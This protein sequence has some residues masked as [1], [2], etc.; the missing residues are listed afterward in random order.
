MREVFLSKKPATHEGTS[1]QTGGFTVLSK[2]QPSNFLLFL[3]P[4]N[5][6]LN[7]TPENVDYLTPST[8]HLA[9]KRSL[10]MRKL[11]LQNPFSEDKINFTFFITRSSNQN[12]P[13]GTREETGLLL[14]SEVRNTGTCWLRIS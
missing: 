3:N 5:M 6:Y 13:S 1:V 11:I 2:P 8:F 7:S 14:N 4:C 9:L 10:V 12:V